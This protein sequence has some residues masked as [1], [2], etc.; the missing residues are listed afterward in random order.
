[1]TGGRHAIRHKSEIAAY[2]SFSLDKVFVAYYT[3][4][5]LDVTAARGGA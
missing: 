5:T 2:T 1:M 3:R 4:K